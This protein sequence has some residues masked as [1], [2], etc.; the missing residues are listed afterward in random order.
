MNFC[1]T[2]DNMLYVHVNTDDNELTYNCKTCGKEYNASINKTNCVYEENY[3]IDVIRKETL[4]NEYTFN[5]PTLPKAIGIKCP[6]KECPS[7]KPNIIY[8]NY[9]NKNMKYIYVCLDCKK[10]K[11]EPY[12][13]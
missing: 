3:N 5:D 9:D 2:C 10:E 4:L 7:K 8:I 6:N 12:I 11:V 1:D 13:W